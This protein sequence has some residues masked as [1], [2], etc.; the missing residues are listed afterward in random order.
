MSTK[1]ILCID[2]EPKRIDTYITKLRDSGYTVI[3]ASTGAEGL[4]MAKSE[5]PDL[6]LLDLKMPDMN[7]IEVFSKLHEDPELKDIKVIFLTAFSDPT[8]P[9]TDFYFAKDIGAT[10]FVRKGLGLEE[11]MAKIQSHLEPGA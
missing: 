1:K 8:I 6:I 11:F 10:D 5:K 9:E 3:F 4:Q 7:G 2:N